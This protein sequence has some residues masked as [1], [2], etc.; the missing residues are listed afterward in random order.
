MIPKSE[1]QVLSGFPIIKLLCV[2]VVW[3][4]LFEPAL[5]TIPKPQHFVALGLGLDS[6]KTILSY[7]LKSFLSLPSWISFKFVN[8]FPHLDS[9]NC[10]VLLLFQRNSMKK[11]PDLCLHGL[12]SSIRISLSLLI[13]L[14]MKWFYLIIHQNFLCFT[15]W[16]NPQNNCVIQFFF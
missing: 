10:S 2:V 15:A 11:F 6:I 7:S 9:N 5:F 14:D 3:K 8:L 12:F 1:N 16:W 13:A 4:L